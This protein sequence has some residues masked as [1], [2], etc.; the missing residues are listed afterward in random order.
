LNG[1]LAL[2][3]QLALLFSILSTAMCPPSPAQWLHVPDPRIPR[4]T[5][6][7]PHL[8]APAPRKADGK[9]DLS[10]IWQSAGAKYLINLAADVK[11]EDLQMQP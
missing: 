1:R 6:G 11:P 9:P 10:G 2:R 7:K 4:T 5:D 3:F 8:A